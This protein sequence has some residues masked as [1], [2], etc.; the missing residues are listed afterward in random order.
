MQSSFVKGLTLLKALNFF[1]IRFTIFQKASKIKVVKTDT[2]DEYYGQYDETERIL[3]HFLVSIIQD[4]GANAQYTVL[5]TSKQ[6]AL[7]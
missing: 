7:V 4:Y 6:N 5:D 1:Q 3:D 2:G